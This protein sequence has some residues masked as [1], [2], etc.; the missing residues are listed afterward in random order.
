MESN[1]FNTRPSG[2]FT[3]D[4]VIVAGPPQ[5]PEFGVIVE[6]QYEKCERKRR[7][8]AR[9][10]MQL[11][12]MLDRPAH[13]LVIAPVPAVAAFY[14]IPLVTI[15]PGY[16]FHPH[17]VGP[18]A[19]PPITDPVEAAAN[20]ELSLLSVMAHGEA[21]K[22]VVRT[23]LDVVK[24]I[25]HAKGNTYTEHCWN[26]STNAVRAIMEEIMKTEEWPVFSPFAREHFGKGKAEGRAEGRAES[27][28][29]AVLVVLASR[30]ITLDEGARERIES[31]RDSEVLTSWL[32]RAVNAQTVEGLFAE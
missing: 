25:P 2:D 1:D 6:V 14:D 12:L 17:V 24:S 20:I 15:L 30:G 5:S 18:G 32:A 22:D 16:T 3:P 27:L 7:Q 9:Y 11:C 4:T 29:D 26:I 31:C 28:A 10:A 19:I 21:D 23:F 8:L 13:V